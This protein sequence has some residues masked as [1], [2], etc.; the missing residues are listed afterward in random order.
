MN[1]EVLL[2][3][4]ELYEENNTFKVVYSI[5]R[6]SL[7][8]GKAGEIFLFFAQPVHEYNIKGQ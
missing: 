7:W 6:I 1:Q 8:E 3:G 5:K 2:R 4:M